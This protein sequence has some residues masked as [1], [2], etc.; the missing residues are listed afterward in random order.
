MYLIT[1]PSV[2]TEKIV[3][4]HTNKYKELFHSNCY[5]EV[6]WMIQDWYLYFCLLQEFTLFQIVC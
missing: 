1:A 5:F 2:R 4:L 6:I 3:A